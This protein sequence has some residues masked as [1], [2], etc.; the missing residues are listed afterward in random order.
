MQQCDHYDADV[1][2]QE[3]EENIIAAPI[4][5]EVMKPSRARPTPKKPM[6]AIAVN[7]MFWGLILIA[8]EPMYPIKFPAAKAAITMP[9]AAA[10]SASRLLAMIG[11][12]T[13][14]GPVKRK[15]KAARMTNM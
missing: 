4:H 10:P 15:L 13:M 5:V 6:I 11:M 2:V 1:A 3:P 9:N 8:P 14:R 7:P 12:P